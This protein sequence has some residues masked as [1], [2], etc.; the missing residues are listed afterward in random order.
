M[1]LGVRARDEHVWA[2]VFGKIVWQIV[3][4]IQLHLDLGSKN[5]NWL[6]LI[7]F[8]VWEDINKT[9]WTHHAFVWYTSASTN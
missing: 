2:G 4:Q 8:V 6:R 1:F 7:S 5:K 9:D 3:I